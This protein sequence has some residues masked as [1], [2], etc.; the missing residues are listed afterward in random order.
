MPDINDALD[1][2]GGDSIL[3]LFKFVDAWNGVSVDKGDIIDQI[4]AQ[5][6]VLEVSEAIYLYSQWKEMQCRESGN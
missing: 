5:R 2:I 1:A 4:M 6:T 3:D